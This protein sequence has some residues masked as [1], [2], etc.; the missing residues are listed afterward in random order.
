VVDA[1][2][3]DRCGGSGGSGHGV[4][5]RGSRVGVEPPREEQKH[6]LQL[7]LVETATG[8]TNKEQLAQQP[9]RKQHLREAEAQA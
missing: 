5:R 6:Q 7:Q 1:G 8:A 3:R 9:M 2:Q 4:G